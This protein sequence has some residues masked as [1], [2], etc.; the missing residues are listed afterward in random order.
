MATD[1]RFKDKVVLVTGATGQQGAA[2][3]RH[4][5]ERG[6]PVRALVRNPDDP[7]ARSIFNQGTE[8]ARGDFEDT[9]SLNSALDGAYAAYSVQNWRD[10]DIDGEVRQG[11]NMADAARR[12]GISL[13]VYSS[14]AAAEQSTGIPHFDSKFR[15]EEHIRQ[16]GIHYT[17]VRPVFFMENWLAM[18]AGIEGGALAMPLGPETRLQMVAVDDI[19]GMVASAI[20]RPGKWQDRAVELAGEE[21]SMTEL[22]QIFSRVTGREVRYTQTP[23]DEFEAKAGHE[24][25]VM[26]RWFDQ[27]GYHVDISAV[28]QEYPKLTSFDHWL[29]VNWH[30]ATRSAG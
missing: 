3:M 22:A 11:A 4:L 12:A 24:A 19:G 26:F 8:L 15:V 27:V 23:W 30:S 29:N 6:F 7:K 18:R 28:R 2:S 25:A 10:S 17:I 20:E 1:K 21:L 9:A 5:R 16:T 14:V 13:L